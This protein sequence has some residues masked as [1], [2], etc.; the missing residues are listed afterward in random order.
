MFSRL[1]HSSIFPIV[2]AVFV[3]YNHS[4]SLTVFSEYLSWGSSSLTHQGLVENLYRNRIITDNRI[5]NAMLK[6]DRA[7]FTDQKSEAYYDRPQPSN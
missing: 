3:I 6:V 1:L 7:D 4:T 5:K 2:I